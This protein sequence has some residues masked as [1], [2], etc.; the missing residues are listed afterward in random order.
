[1]TFYVYLFNVLS[2]VSNGDKL[3]LTQVGVGGEIKYI[4]Y[5]NPKEIDSIH[6]IIT[7]IW[8]FPSS[9]STPNSNRNKSQECIVRKKILN[10][11][12]QSSEVHA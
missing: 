1:M 3:F 2:L 4:G 12:T 8:L 5:T 10:A 7:S 9:H 11:Q 6:L